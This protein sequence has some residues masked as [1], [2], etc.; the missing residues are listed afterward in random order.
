MYSIS[1][2]HVGF[3]D[4]APLEVNWSTGELGIWDSLFLPSFVFGFLIL[5]FYGHVLKLILIQGYGYRKYVIV[6]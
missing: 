5:V 4:E 1:E 2:K 3:N 6:C